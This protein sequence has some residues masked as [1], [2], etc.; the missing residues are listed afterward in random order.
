MA[1]RQWVRVD[2]AYFRNPKV[3][4]VGTDG[5]LLHLAAIL[6]L[7]EHRLDTGLLP[8][9]AVALLIRDVGVRKAD[10]V[11]RDL[12]RHGLWHEL[13]GGGYIV[14]DYGETNGEA[15]EA[16][17]DRERKRRERDRSRRRREDDEA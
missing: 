13:G 12:V 2:V 3:L 8:A 16:A 1:S 4:R 9:E 14:H 7:G 17:Q 6:Y 5:A 15:S 10:L 11:V